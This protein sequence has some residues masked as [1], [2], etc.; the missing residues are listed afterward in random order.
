MKKIFEG[1]WDANFHRMGEYI[2][3]VMGV[4]HTTPVNFLVNPPLGQPASIFRV[5][6]FYFE[7]VAK[8][9]GKWGFKK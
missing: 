6:F 2:S 9:S 5:I 4:D 7:W 8:W 1:V 3:L